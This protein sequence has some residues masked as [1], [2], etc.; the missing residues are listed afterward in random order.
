M[1][2]ISAWPWLEARLLAIGAAGMAF[3]L[4]PGRWAGPLRLAS[5]ASDGA[6]ILGVA[7]PICFEDTVPDICRRLV[8][9]E[10]RRQASVILNVSNDGWFG[11]WAPAR[12]S[13]FEFSRFRA[14]ENRT[15]MVRVVNTGDSGWIDSDGR[16][17]DRLSGPEAGW[18]LARPR[19]D[20]RRPIYARV[21][22]LPATLWAGGLL[23]L[24]VWSLLSRTK[25][26]VE[27]ETI[28]D[29]D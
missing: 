27:T 7:T 5:S 11:S 2:Y 4:D 29:S 20:D 16:I 17:R 14:I 8:W 23:V 12:E 6:E 15:P 13:H 24:L 19:L 9:S 21:G 10:G 18:L 3:D 1:P 25:L 26:D 28:A 22:E